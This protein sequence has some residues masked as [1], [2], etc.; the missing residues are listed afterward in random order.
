MSYLLYDL[1]ILPTDV[2]I[3][4][5]IQVLLA[6]RMLRW[7][8][9]PASAGDETLRSEENTPRLTFGEPPPLCANISETE[10]DGSY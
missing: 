1:T 10:S 9:S 7:V 2:K 6:T 8:L 3:M 4:N 5:K